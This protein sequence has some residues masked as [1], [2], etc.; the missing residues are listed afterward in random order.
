MT[1][2]LLAAAGDEA[3]TAGENAPL[4]ELARQLG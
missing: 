4:I 2:A 3:M 1:T